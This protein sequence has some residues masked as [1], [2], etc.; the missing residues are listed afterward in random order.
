MLLRDVAA[1]CLMERDP[2][3][4]LHGAYLLEELGA[5]ILQY[6]TA[7]PTDTSKTMEVSE[8][9]CSFCGFSQVFPCQLI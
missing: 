4:Q 9:L 2:S 7:A 1:W 5:V 3:V 6:T 8:V